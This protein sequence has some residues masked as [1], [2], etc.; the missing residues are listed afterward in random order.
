MDHRPQ[1]TD[2]SRRRRDLLSP[3]G[4]KGRGGG[5][6]LLPPFSRAGEYLIFHGTFL[7]DPSSIRQ[8]VPTS[9]ASPAGAGTGRGR[10]VDGMPPLTDP[11]Q[12]W[13]KLTF[14]SLWLFDFSFLPVLPVMSAKAFRCIPT[15]FGKI[16]FLYAWVLAYLPVLLVS[17]HHSGTWCCHSFIDG[18]RD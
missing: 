5:P 9:A 1:K 2:Q 7:V 15:I 6:L 13:R 8:P 18:S 12:L 3:Q 17:F 11:P 4:S 10:W 14:S 16:F